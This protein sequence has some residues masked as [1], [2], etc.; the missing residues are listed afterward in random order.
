MPEK[1]RIGILGCASIADRSIAPAI[2]RLQ[3][4]F[5]LAGVASRSLDKAQAFSEIHSIQAYEGY[6]AL[7]DSP[8]LDAVYI[9]LPN[10]EHFQWIEEALS[11][12]LHVL[13]EKSLGCSY[14]EVDTLCQLAERKQLVLFENFQFRFHAQLTAIKRIVDAGDIGEL[15]CVRSSFGFPPF[16]DSDNIRYRKEL[17]GG[18]LLDAGAYPIKLAQIF[19]PGE[20]TVTAAN[21]VFDPVSGVDIWGGAH[22]TQQSGE[23]FAELAFGFDNYY[24]C[25]MNLW[26]S[27]GCLSSDRIF[28]AGPTVRTA[29]KLESKQ[30]VRTIELPEDDH[31][32]NMLLWFHQLIGNEQ[33][34]ADELQQNRQQARLIEELRLKANEQR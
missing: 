21:L 29:I 6:S 2:N 33:Q 8:G 22:L 16:E 4:K 19:M 1:T 32:Q 15:R 20:C 34:M 17:G 12:G 23:L 10:S 5:E 26:G 31:F 25:S 9:P 28:T 3:D 11:R 27:E 24:Q 14:Q 13:V 18:A 30:T 7:L